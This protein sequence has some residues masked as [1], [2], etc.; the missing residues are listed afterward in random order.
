MC[1]FPTEIHGSQWE[2]G[3]VQAHLTKLQ[4]CPVLTD[5]LWEKKK[6]HIIEDVTLE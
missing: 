5:S 1:L 4:L 3:L 2:P 6:N